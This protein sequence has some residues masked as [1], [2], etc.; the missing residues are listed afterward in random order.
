MPYF[1]L[2]LESNIGA[3]R[4]SARGA[5]FDL[6][7]S[8]D[9][10]L[11]AATLSTSAA[12]VDRAALGEALG[13]CIAEDR[14]PLDDPIIV[15]ATHAH[16]L[17][18]LDVGALLDSATEGRQRAVVHKHAPAILRAMG[19]VVA[20]IDEAVAQVA[21]GSDRYATLG[22][23]PGHGLRFND[24]MQATMAL[25][26][27]RYL[28]QGWAPLVL[29]CGLRKV[30]D[31]YRPLAFADVN[32]SELR[33]LAQRPENLLHHGHRLSFASKLEAFDERIANVRREEAD[34]TDRKAREMSTGVRL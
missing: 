33:T 25:N 11:E 3:V 23:L 5:E 1:Q 16:V 17:R 30:D 29:G 26:R 12:S 9:A 10:D 27:F 34:E 13:A 18:L 4:R 20:E 2:D 32:L 19:K 31:F 8:F 22:Q 15:R 14:D 28:E 6:P 21:L 24:T 7:K